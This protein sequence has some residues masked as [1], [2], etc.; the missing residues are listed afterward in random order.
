MSYVVCQEWADNPYPVTSP[1]WR[2]RLCGATKLL[3]DMSRT[4]KGLHYTGV[5]VSAWAAVILGGG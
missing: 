4:P 5:A 3:I 1:T 2:I